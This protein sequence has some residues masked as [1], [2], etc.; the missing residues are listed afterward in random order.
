MRRKIEVPENLDP[1]IK[2]IAKRNEG[3]IDDIYGHAIRSV[4]TYSFGAAGLGK[5]IDDQRQALIEA[6]RRCI[7][8]HGEKIVPFLRDELREIV[9]EE[10]LI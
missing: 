5:N 9:E 1:E 8:R 6:A 10:D 3:L 4:L 7:S 2:K